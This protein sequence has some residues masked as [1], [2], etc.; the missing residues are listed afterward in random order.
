MK[1]ESAYVCLSL[2]YL[3]FCFMVIYNFQYIMS[4]ASLFS[5]IIR[6]NVETENTSEPNEEWVH[7][8]KKVFVRRTT[9]FY[10]VNKNKL[11]LYYLVDSTNKTDYTFDLELKIMYSNTREFHVKIMNSEMRKSRIFTRY[12]Y[13]FSKLQVEFNIDSYLID[14]NIFDFHDANMT[15]K[16]QIQAYLYDPISQSRTQYPLDVG[17]TQWREGSKN[18]SMICSGIHFG[19]GDSD[20]PSNYE[21]LSWWL[22]ANR[23]FGF[24]KVVLTNNSIPDTEAYRRLFAK[25]AG[26]VEINQ[27]QYLPNFMNKNRSFY[28]RK[29]SEMNKLYAPEYNLFKYL[30]YN[31]CFMNNIDKY[32]YILVQDIDELLI[33]RASPSTLFDFDL[34]R[35]T[36]VLNLT[37]SV[38]SSSL[39]SL[40]DSRSSCTA[41]DN[42][43][44]SIQS[45]LNLLELGFNKNQTLYFKMDHH[46]NNASVDTILNKLEE[47]LLSI[48]TS[49]YELPH[50]VRI[51]E[52]SY[53]GKINYTIWFDSHEDVKYAKNLVV[54]YRLL[55]D[56]FKVQNNKSLSV[57]SKHNIFDRFLVLSGNLTDWQEGKTLH[58]TDVTKELGIH[59]TEQMS[60]KERKSLTRTIDYELGH[61]SHFRWQ[62]NLKYANKSAPILNMNV[63]DLKFDFNY[64]YCY[65]PQLLRAISSTALNDILK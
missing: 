28:F 55:V 34:N 32:Q 16:L 54:V 17:I 15:E 19:Y 46:L 52:T 22:E 25:H 7:L 57:H 58:N 38:D 12:K 1:F 6:A 9:V 42:A 61:M 10:L 8:N 26:F 53:Y 50:H 18:G 3:P 33:P 35:I 39:L 41:N 13:T 2:F 49:E 56:A 62:T 4:P 60:R 47:H 20:S 48:D 64:F 37:K 5:P 11:K 43:T 21:K 36:S 65:Y 23:Q 63:K 27:L 59:M 44:S 29:F 45:Y 31:E 24:A 30:I 51:N 14:N 40:L